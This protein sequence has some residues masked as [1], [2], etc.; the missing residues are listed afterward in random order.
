MK[1]TVGTVGK[2]SIYEKSFFM[3]LIYRVT[4]WFYALVINGFF[5]RVFTAYSDIENLFEESWVY[6]KLNKMAL[7]KK[8]RKSLK[9]G[10]SKAFE[11]SK[12]ITAVSELLSKSLKCRLKEYGAA[13]TITGA[14]GLLIYTLEGGS[15]YVFFREPSCIISCVAFL[16]VGLAFLMSKRT[17]SDALYESHIMSEL[18]FEGFGI[19]KEF[20]TT[21]NSENRGYLIPVLLGAVFG[22]LSY[23][24]DPTYYVAALV[25]VVAATMII[26]FPELGMLALFAIIP[27]AVYLPH[28]AITLFAVTLF[29][30]ASYLVK[31]IRGKRLAR[32]RLIDI[33]VLAFLGVRLFSGFFSAGGRNSLYQAILGCGLMLAYFLGV[34]LIRNREWLKRAV[35]TFISFSVFTLIIGVFQIFYGG[36]ESGWLDSS[37]FS[38]ISVRIT[39]TFENPNNYAAY[40]LLVIPFIIGGVLESK[41]TKQI[42]IYSVILALSVICMAQ[43]WSR[44]AWLGLCVSLV[45]FFLVYSR[46]SLPYVLVGGTVGALGI[47]YLAPD[48][49]HRFLSIGNFAESS[50]SYRISAWKGIYQMLNS[51]NWLAGIG[52]GEAS[53]SALYPMFAYSGASAV[54]HAHSLYLQIVAESGILGLV[55]LCLIALLFMQNCFEY[56]YRIKNAEGRT[57][58]IAGMAAIVGF[59]VMGLADYVWY[60]SRVYLTFWL[61]MAMVNANIR[62]DFAERNISN[63]GEKSNV[64]SAN[65][66]IDPESI[67]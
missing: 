9:L 33:T 43:T 54:K 65:L 34:N 18:L 66:E 48:I 24:V 51:Y 17:L 45:V 12:I 57:V 37:T 52:F 6:K 11:S 10:I 36:F 56:L 59:L 1:K 41:T 19:Q 67:Y 2:K 38:E 53:F 62:I 13:F 46:K 40:L 47:S 22:S 35:T 42:A 3:N 63:G 50:V 44:G 4:T 15:F 64:Y 5:G 30:G 27:L 26:I 61:V 58:A 28:P 32:F 7:F 16:A 14:V 39:S 20:F 49:G 21:E 55:V 25:V 31:L 29:T 8:F 60:N 23:F